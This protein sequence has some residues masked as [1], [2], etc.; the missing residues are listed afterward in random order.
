MNVRSVGS[1]LTPSDLLLGSIHFVVKT[2][3]QMINQRTPMKYEA[4]K[5][6]TANLNIFKTTTVQTIF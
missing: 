3:W 5:I 2:S 4:I 1:S 6:K